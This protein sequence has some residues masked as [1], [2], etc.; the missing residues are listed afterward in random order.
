MHKRTGLNR[1]NWQSFLGVEILGVA[2]GALALSMATGPAQSVFAQTNSPPQSSSASQVTISRSE[3]VQAIQRCHQFAILQI[4]QKQIDAQ[5]QRQ[6]TEVGCNHDQTCM[7]NAAATYTAT[8]NDL[9]KQS[10][11]ADGVYAKEIAQL[12]YHLQNMLTCT[13]DLSSCPANAH[14]L[15]ATPVV[16][17][18]CADLANELDPN[19]Q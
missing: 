3:F 12:D 6:N 11:N 2:I 17:W 4:T 16:Q 13:V 15:Y 14:K 19:A 8:I 5:T 9:Q 7:Q 1:A 10:N 18:N